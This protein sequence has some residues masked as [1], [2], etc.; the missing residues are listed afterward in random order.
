MGKSPTESRAGD[1]LGARYALDELLVTG[2]V[3]DTYLATD[4]KGGGKKL[5]VKLLR[6]ELALR[7]KVVDGFVRTPKTLTELEHPNV[8]RVIAVES[9]ETGIPFV[10]E[11]RVEGEPLSRSFSGFGE[12]MP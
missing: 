11:E 3:Y 7:A 5:V 6:P 9:D 2:E 8:A 4:R 10:V 1:V 12:G